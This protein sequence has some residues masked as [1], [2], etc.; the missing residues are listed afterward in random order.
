[1]SWFL[2]SLLGYGTFSV[3]V[4]LD[5]FILTK[6]VP[7]PVI[8]V[9]YT[10]VLFLPVW[11]FAPFIHLPQNFL[12]WV[13]VF[14]PGVFFV[15]N[16]WALYLSFQKS[17]ISHVGPLDGAALAFFSLLLSIV[18]LGDRFSCQNLIAAGLFLLVKF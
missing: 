8:F 18:F 16:L 4:I 7:K 10:C 14:L 17:E 2:I 1:M 5:K 9:F 3:V 11:L 15:L 12:E 6:S 13:K